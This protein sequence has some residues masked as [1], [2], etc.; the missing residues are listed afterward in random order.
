MKLEIKM[1]ADQA[2]AEVNALLD[3]KNIFP[4]RR[5]A[6]QQAV[7]SVVEAMQYGFVTI[8]EDGTITQNMITPVDSVSVITYKARIAPE[9]MNRQIASLKIDNATTRN[10]AYIKAYT[11]LL[12]NVINK[13]E[14]TDR[15]T[16]ES[17]ALFFW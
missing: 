8:N 14:T 11:G 13:L 1:P 10:V 15:N 4:K 3:K 17:I 5:E 9:V 2:E 6:L 16:A 7:D 12:E